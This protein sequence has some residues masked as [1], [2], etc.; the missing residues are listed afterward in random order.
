MSEVYI[1]SEGKIVRTAFFWVI[2]HWVLV[3]FQDTVQG[4]R[5]II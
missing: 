4:C 1:K 2:M 5:H 3:V